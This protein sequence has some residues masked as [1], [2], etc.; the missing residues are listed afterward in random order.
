ML[1]FKFEEDMSIPTQYEFLDHCVTK[2]LKIKENQ[3]VKSD[4][5]FL[6]Y[7]IASEDI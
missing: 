7:L 5:G 3:E 1:K 4:C 2:L 6:K